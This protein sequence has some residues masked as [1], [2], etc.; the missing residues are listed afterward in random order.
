MTEEWRDIVEY[1]GKYQVSN[2][3]RIRRFID[4]HVMSQ[5]NVGGYKTVGLS[6]RGCC[7]Q[8]RV[9]RLVAGAFIPNPDNYPVVNHMDENPSNNRVDNLEWCTVE[10]N[11]TYGT[12][13][14][15]RRKTMF[16]GENRIPVVQYTMDRR[17][18]ADY[19]SIAAAAT[20]TGI[21]ASNICHCLK[22][23]TGITHGYR[24][25]RILVG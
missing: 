2:L 12:A 5:V 16:T 6:K 21:E 9:H 14:E 10:Y 15:R 18:I 17:V 11:T 13:I 1:E 22:S 4:R 7:L 3:G 23:G 19:P 25:A 20:A 24:W 8:F